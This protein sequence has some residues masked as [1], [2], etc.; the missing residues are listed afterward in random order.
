MKTYT[1]CLLK[2]KTLEQTLWIPEKFAIKDNCVKV[3]GI[4]WVIKE[5]YNSK[6]LEDNDGTIVE[7]W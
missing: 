1:Q 5:T 3:D 6:E 4:I 2:Y 7:D